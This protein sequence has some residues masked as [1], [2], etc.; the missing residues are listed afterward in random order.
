MINGLLT[1]MAGGVLFYKLPRYTK[2]LVPL[3]FAIQPICIVVNTKWYESLDKGVKT[4]IDDVFQRIDMSN[5]YETTQNTLIQQWNQDPK[6]E[7]NKLS[8]QESKKWKDLMTTAVQDMLSGIDPK[9]IKAIN[10][11]R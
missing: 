9:Y 7:L 6:T 5:F 8:T 10:S 11:V 4:A 3:T 1:D 2:Y